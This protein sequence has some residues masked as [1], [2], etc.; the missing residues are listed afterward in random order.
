MFGECH[1]TGVLHFQ[2]PIERNTCGFIPQKI[3]EDFCKKTLSV[4]KMLK[5]KIYP[6]GDKSKA[7]T[8]P[9]TI[10]EITKYDYNPDPDGTGG[11][12][13]IPLDEN[14]KTAIKNAGGEA[15]FSFD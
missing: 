13:Q 1:E 5:M 10:G 8:I 11:Y 12:E 2:R 6:T 3:T 9:I 7:T 14:A 15:S 4:Q